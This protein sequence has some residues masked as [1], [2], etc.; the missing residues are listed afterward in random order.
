[1]DCFIRTTRLD[2]GTLDNKILAEIDL[3][4]DKVAD[5]IMVRWSD[6]DCETYSDYRIVDLSFHRPNLRQCGEFERRT[7]EL[8]YVG[9]KP[10]RL[11]DM[12]LEIG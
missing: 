8:E 9:N 10:L 11:T 6:D 3:I 2:G 1:M 7:I 4:G 12:E 5:T